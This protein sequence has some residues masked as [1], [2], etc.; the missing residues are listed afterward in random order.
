MLVRGS[1][2]GSSL[3][4]LRTTSET[5]IPLTQEF[6]EVRLL[7]KQICC[8][9]RRHEETRYFSS[10]MVRKIDTASSKNDHFLKILGKGVI[11][12]LDCEAAK[13]INEIIFLIQN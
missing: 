12:L 5:R 1:I 9:K 11:E 7:E 10:H 6:N 4:N 2:T 3:A 8:R 13:N